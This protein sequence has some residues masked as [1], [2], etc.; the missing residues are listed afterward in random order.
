MSQMNKA[1]F[2]QLKKISF[3]GFFG[4]RWLLLPWSRFNAKQLKVVMDQNAAHTKSH[5][6]FIPLVFDGKWWLR[7]ILPLI[8]H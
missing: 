2:Q 5:S 8:S 7:N 6:G 3:H 4:L 1:Y